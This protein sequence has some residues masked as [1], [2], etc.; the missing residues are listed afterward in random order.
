V[1]TATALA[2]AVAGCGSSSSSSH[3]SSTASTAAAAPASSTSTTTAAKPSRPLRLHI[4]SPRAG[5]R[6]GQNLTVRVAL[7]GTASGHVHSFR[8]VLDGMLTRRGNAR[9]TFHGLAPGRQHLV[10]S[11]PGDPGLHAAAIFVVRTPPVPA[12]PVPVATTAAP[13]STTATPA[14]TTPAPTTAAPT[15]AAPAPATTTTA[16]P[17]PAPASGIPQGNGGDMDGDNNGGPSDG[18]GGV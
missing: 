13:T 12:A 14:P 17:A 3:S 1:A 2:L 11:V 18:D 8:Y 5:A 10:V 4:L 7:T 6:T 15:T 16:A 9:L